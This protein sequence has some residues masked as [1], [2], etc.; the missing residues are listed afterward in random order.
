[1]RRGRPQNERV[2]EVGRRCRIPVHCS[3]QPDRSDHSDQPRGNPHCTVW[4]HAA[5]GRSTGRALSCCY[6][7]WVAAS[8]ATSPSLSS[9]STSTL[10]VKKACVEL[11]SARLK[12]PM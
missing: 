11:S 1:M 9:S 8:A 7:Y 6:S 10:T 12:F 4:C 3:D 5:D 2:S